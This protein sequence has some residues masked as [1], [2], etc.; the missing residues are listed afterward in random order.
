QQA[1]VERLRAQAARDAEDADHAGSPEC[2]GIGVA[3]SSPR[4]IAVA[5]GR[6]PAPWG[7]RCGEAAS[8]GEAFGVADRFE[9]AGDGLRLLLRAEVDAFGA[10]HVDV[11]DTEEAEH[12]AQVGLLEI[13][14]L[15]R[16]FAVDAATRGR[17]DDTLATGET[18]RPGCGVAE[19]P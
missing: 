12:L 1:R 8:G 16:T 17:D 13:Q 11:G 15:G 5:T 10:H 19:S 6:V 3:P 18:L 14:G 9:R 4:S 7:K 2:A